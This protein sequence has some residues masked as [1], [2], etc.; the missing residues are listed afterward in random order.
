MSG[1]VA[2]VSGRATFDLVRE[3][4]GPRVGMLN[5]L[6]SM[7]IT[8]L[9]YTAEIGGVALALQL[10][11]SVHVLLIVPVVAILVWL[12]LWRGGGRHPPKTLRRLSGCAGGGGGAAGGGGG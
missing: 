7:L 9:T 4:L 8:L 3:R 1:R 10:I 2:A 11:A 6:A 5:L 12:V